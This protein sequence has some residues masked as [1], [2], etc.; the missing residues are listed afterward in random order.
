[1]A[2]LALALLVLQRFPFLMLTTS[3]LI[4]DLVSHLNSKKEEEEV[5]HK[6]KKKKK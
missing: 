3:V 2:L 1:M 6:K 4:L 5:F